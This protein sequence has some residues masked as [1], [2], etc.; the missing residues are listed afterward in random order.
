M[1]QAIGVDLGGTKINAGV[2]DAN[3]QILALASE[4]TPQTGSGQDILALI[5]RLCQDLQE[6]YQIQSIGIGTPGL[7]SDGRIMGCTPNLSDWE[8]RDLKAYFTQALSCPVVVDNDANVACY[9][10]WKVGAGKGYHDLVVLTLGTGLGSG[11]VLKGELSRGHHLLGIGFGHMIVDAHGRYCNCG[12]RGCLETYVSGKGLIKTYLL[13]GGNSGIKGPEI[14]VQAD[15]GDPIAKMA[16]EY[17]LDLLAIGLVNILNTLAPEQILL[18]GGISAQGE[19]RLLEPLR[20]KVKGIMSMPLRKP[21]MLALARLGPEA[22]M[23]GAGLLAL[24]E[25][26]GQQ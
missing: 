10:E 21:E 5:C 14:F 7:V 4:V 25:T 15:A 11:L 9:A 18:G 2:I 12:Q 1:S 6:N 19:K 24:E 17:M 23:I 16:I 26:F 13:L 20:E 8:G 3:G 22:G